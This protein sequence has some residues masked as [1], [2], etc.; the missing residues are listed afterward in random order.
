M[1]NKRDI[2]N[3][4]C[5]AMILEHTLHELGVNPAPAPAELTVIFCGEGKPVGGHRNGPG[6]HDYYLVHTVLSGS[7]LYEVNGKRYK[8]KA[9]DTFFIFPGEPFFYEADDRDPWSYVWV[10]FIGSGAASHLSGIGVTASAPVIHGGGRKIPALYR[11]L[12]SRL[13]Q[14]DNASQI[15]SLES[16]GYLR[17]LLAEF[18]IA[19]RHMLPAAAAFSSDIERRIALAVHLLSTHYAQSVSIERLSQTCGYHRTHFSAMFKQSTG[20]SPK[21]YLLKVRMERAEALLA[22]ALPIEQVASSVGYGDPLYFSKQFHKWSSRS[23]SAFRK[24][25]RSG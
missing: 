23:P 10:A 5:A 13:L 19:N 8:C 18:A 24:S 12:R 22:T 9:G 1:L 20:Y 3:G 15:T 17:L 4:R 11:R 14:A 2:G 25:L 16:A 7:G 6:V 21:Q